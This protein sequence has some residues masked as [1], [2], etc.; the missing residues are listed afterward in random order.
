MVADSHR[1]A[2]AETSNGLLNGAPSCNSA[3]LGGAAVLIWNDV[4]PEGRTQ[5][6]QWHDKEHMPERLAL[7]GFRRG[8]RWSRR[9]HS[10]EWLTLYEAV[11][12]S[13]LVSRE[14]LARLNA[15]TPGT[16]AALTHFR[17]TSRAVCKVVHSVGSSTGGQMLAMRLS[18]GAAN[19]DAMCRYLR[20]EG[21]P[22]AMARAGVVACHLLVAD[23]SAS[24][25]K[26]A[27]SSTREFDVPAWVLLCEASTQDAAADLKNVVEGGGFG[28]LGVE[29]RD[30]Y[31]VYALE[32]CRLSLSAEAVAP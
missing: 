17:N 25:V 15:P 11:D 28:R 22:R 16:V 4:A 13:A 30:D 24:Y 23:A 29:V 10:P 27:E 5:F 12:V 31:A 19:S 2:D 21:F 18:V 9:G 14:Y 20:E 7:P 6:Y 32:I 1:A 8:R 26:T 3:L